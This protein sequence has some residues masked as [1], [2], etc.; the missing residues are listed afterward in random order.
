MA[1]TTPNFGWPVPTSSDLL[2]NGATAIE[3]LGDAIDASLLDLKGG[4][5]GQVLAKASGTDMDF[6]WVTDATGIPATI[7]D[8][9]GDIIAATAAD[10]AARLAVG[11]ANQVLTVDSSTATGLKWATPAAAASGLTKIVTGDFSAVAGVAINGCFTST[12]K[13]Y[14]LIVNGLLDSTDPGEIYLQLQ[15]STSTVENI[16]YFGCSD[17]RNESGTLTTLTTPNASKFILG[18]ARGTARHNFTATIT[19]VGNTSEQAGVAC[20]GN[21]GNQGYNIFG[22]IAASARTYT[23]I[24]LS[25]QGNI[26]GTY[27]VYGLEN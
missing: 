24:Y 13:K 6:S 26:T 3:G 9:K 27:T 15:Y 22:G 21:L 23:G 17:S 1:T 11:T 16:S 19:G 20:Y 2:K 14:L 7:F 5:S 10:T 12:Y 25:G 4:T 8:A 18:K